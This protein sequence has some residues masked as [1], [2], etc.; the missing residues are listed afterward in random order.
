[1]LYGALSSCPKAV[2]NVFGHSL[3]FVETSYGVEDSFGGAE[4][5]GTKKWLV[6]KKK[7]SLCSI[8]NPKYQPSTVCFFKWCDVRRSY[9]E[10]GTQK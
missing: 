6:K 9:R 1:V 4:A 7:E 10:F 8:E 3:G 2:V 5:L